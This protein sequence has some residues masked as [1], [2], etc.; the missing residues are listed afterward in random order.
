MRSRR[1]VEVRSSTARAAATRSSESIVRAVT[2]SPPSARRWPPARR[3]CAASRRAPAASR[4]R[5]QHTSTSPKA[6]LGG[7]SRRQHRVRAHA[8]EERAR[9]AR[10][11]TCAAPAPPPTG[12][13]VE[14]EARQRTADARGATQRPENRVG[15]R[16][17]VARPS[18][19]I[20][21]RT[22]P[23]RRPERPAVASTERSSTAALPSASG[24]ARGAGGCTHSTTEPRKRQRV[25]RK[26]ER[27]RH[28]VDRRADVVAEAGQ[29]QLGR[30]AAAADRPRALVD[31]A[32]SGPLAPA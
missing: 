16:V 15:S 27:Q 21:R 17:P 5:A 10:R 32:P 29:R 6:A 8:G 18:G 26:G 9:R 25:R 3:R 28:R 2:I 24:C 13:P 12:A 7:C 23:R 31:H 22:H 4:P 20:S 1:G 19:A 30:A 11:E 14:P